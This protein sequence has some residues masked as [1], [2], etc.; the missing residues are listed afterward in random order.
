MAVGG[1]V[2]LSPKP[3]AEAE[4]LER[5]LEVIEDVR[6]EP[7]NVL[8]LVLRDPE[9]P[10]D[11]LMLELFTDQAAIAAHRVASHSVVKGPAVHALL[12]SPMQLRRLE[13]IESS[14]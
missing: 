8:A 5:A 2:R 7:G 14:N 10:N 9:L 3:G 6:R 4:L 12:E 1:F 13:T 11:V